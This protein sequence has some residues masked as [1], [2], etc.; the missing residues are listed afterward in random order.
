MGRLRNRERS[1]FQGLV[2]DGRPP[3]LALALGL[4][5]AGGAALFLAVTGHGTA[6]LQLLPACRAKGDVV[7]VLKPWGPSRGS[8]LRG[9]SRVRQTDEDSRLKTL[10]VIRGSAEGQNQF[11]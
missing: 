6:I 1:F 8:A 11:S 4:V 7:R 5:A 2:G 3:L 9:L 10:N